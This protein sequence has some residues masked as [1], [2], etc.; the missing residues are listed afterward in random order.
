MKQSLYLR[1]KEL[2]PGSETVRKFS[3]NIIDP[4]DNCALLARENEFLAINF[5]IL[6]VKSAR[7]H[8]NDCFECPSP[9]ITAA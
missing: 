1:A 5:A 7:F 3:F 4:R 8:I 2:F 6:G 9:H